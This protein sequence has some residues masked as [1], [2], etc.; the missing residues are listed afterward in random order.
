MNIFKLT[1]KH[2]LDLLAGE[3]IGW[4]FIIC[5]DENAV[6]FAKN[7]MKIRLEIKI[8]LNRLEAKALNIL[9]KWANERYARYEVIDKTWFHIVEVC[10]VRADDYIRRFTFPNA[11]LISYEEEASEDNETIVATIVV[12]QVQNLPQNIRVNKSW[13]DF[14]AEDAEWEKD[15]L[16]AMAVNNQVAN[17]AAVPGVIKKVAPQVVPKAKNFLERTMKNLGM[18]FNLTRMQT[19]GVK[20]HL[21][22]LANGRVLVGGATPLSHADARRLMEE[23]KITGGLAIDP[24]TGKYVLQEGAI[25][26][27]ALQN[28]RNSAHGMGDNIITAKPSKKSKKERSTQTPSW[29]N[30]EKPRPG[31]SGKDF[32]KRI[33]DET[34]GEGVH[35]KG[36]VSDFNKLR[37]WA[38]RNK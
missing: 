24:A 9:A 7:P 6:P 26:E 14:E 30:N 23:L 3:V 2:N 37:K 11:Y 32:A 31:E 29:F 13:I 17:M 38:D 5:E 18:P 4:K 35:K 22:Y 21:E 8:I 34:F 15:R 25:N 12:G 27:V 20:R 1:G 19:K 28:L 33:L 16:A 10:Y 36:P